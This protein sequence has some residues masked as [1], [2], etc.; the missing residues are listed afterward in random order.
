M[1]P[2]Q[3]LPDWHSL[4]GEQNYDL[5]LFWDFPFLLHMDYQTVIAGSV[6][7]FGFSVPFGFGTDG[8]NY[9]GSS[10]WTTST[11]SMEKQLTQ[12]TRFCTHP[13]FDS[14]GVY[15]VTDPFNTTYISTCYVPVYPEVGDSGFPLDP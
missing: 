2:I 5:G 4:V 1:L 6:T 9:L 7:A 13:T 12:C 8:E 14:A 11:F 15:H 10:M 3:Y